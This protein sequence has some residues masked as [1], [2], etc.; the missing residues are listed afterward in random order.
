MTAFA[1][2]MIA[3]AAQMQGELAWKPLAEY[4]ELRGNKHYKRATE[5]ADQVCKDARQWPFQE[6]LR[7]SLWVLDQTKHICEKL[8]RSDLDG[9]LHGIVLLR[10][11]IEEILLPAFVEW[12]GNEPSNAEPYFQLGLFRTFALD[13]HPSINLREAMRL[14]PSH[15]RAH[16]ALARFIIEAIGG[17]QHELPSGYLG[18]PADDL[19]SLKEVETLLDNRIDANVRRLLDERVSRLRMDAEDWIRLRSQMKGLDWE[20]RVSL[21][22]RR[23]K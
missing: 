21:W 15:A 9:G 1:E 22:S 19:L 23:P 17:S 18:D 4:F 7:F 8:G 3:T 10:S 11:W 5:I 6:R 2:A 14:D 20:S 13:E 12:R 16:E